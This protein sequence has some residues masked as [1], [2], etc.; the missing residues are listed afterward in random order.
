MNGDFSSPQ[1]EKELL[2]LLKHPDPEVRT[3][4]WNCFFDMNQANLYLDARKSLLKRGVSDNLE[5]DTF[6]ILQA[7]WMKLTAHIAEFQYQCEGGLYHYARAIIAF[8]VF[9][10]RRAKQREMRAATM[11]ISL[12]EAEET[13]GDH[14]ISALQALIADTEDQSSPDPLDPEDDHIRDA[15]RIARL[16]FN[17]LSDRDRTLLTERY[18]SRAD[19]KGLASRW[20]CTPNTA[21]QHVFRAKQRFIAAFKT[22]VNQEFEAQRIAYGTYRWLMTYIEEAA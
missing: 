17:Q 12:D 18:V 22:L 13:G 21:R 1:N 6:L 3:F 19:Y 15:A 14:A 9:N 5:E 11:N 10:L 4:G 2:V 8:E 20:G 7:M 16:L